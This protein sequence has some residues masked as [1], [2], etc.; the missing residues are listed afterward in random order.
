MRTSLLA[1]MT[2]RGTSFLAAGAASAAAGW[3]LGERGLFCIGIALLALPLLAAAGA[4]RG[5]YRLGTSRT[6]TPPRVPAGHTATV[7]LRLENV[8][9]VPTG[10]LLAEDTVPY[11]LGTRP[12]YVLDKI[13]RN[14]VREL[15]YPLR[16]DL[17]GKFQIGP[18]QLRVADAFGLVELNRSPSR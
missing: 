13:E 5:Q 16:S 6:I 10:L 11:A 17:R 12:R 2:T 15:T 1:G 14:G 18:L 3:L 9:R 4:R 7:T 8:S